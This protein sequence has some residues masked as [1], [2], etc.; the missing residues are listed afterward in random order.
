MGTERNRKGE[1][2][3][4]EAMCGGSSIPWG[5]DGKPDGERV[6]DA[7]EEAGVLGIWNDD[8]EVAKVES[9]EREVECTGLE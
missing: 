3:G 5:T 7:T 9:V 1:N 4:F 6:G 2:G 8:A